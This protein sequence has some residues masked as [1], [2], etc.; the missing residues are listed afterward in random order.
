MKEM[1]PT[2]CM[3]S[4][5]WY[6]ATTLAERAALRAG[7]VSVRSSGSNNEEV[8]QRLKRWK[9]QPPFHHGSYFA[10]RLA[11]DSLT[12]EDLLALLAE[13]VEVIRSYHSAPPAWLIE[14][15]R[16]FENQDTTDEV[17]PLLEKI[18]D[19]HTQ[20]FLNAVKPLLQ[21]GF[22]RLQAGIREIATSSVR[23][24][25]DPQ[26]ILK[27]FAP[28]IFSSIMQDISRTIVLELNVA[29]VQGRLQ[30]E[31]PEERFHY[32]LQQ[33]AQPENLL[34]L[35]E[36]YPVLARL[37]V[38]KIDRWAT[39]E[40]EFLTR[41]CSDWEQ[42]L[43]VFA[44]SEDPGVL[45]EVHEG[46]GDT[47]RGGHSVMTL[48]WSSGF[49]L[50]YKPRPLAVDEHFQE[51]LAW[52]NKEGQQPALRTFKLINKGTYGWCEFVHAGDC[53]SIE[54]VERFYERQGAYLA[55]LYALEATDFHA[56][57][58]IAS[59]EHPMLIDL[60][61][62]FQPHAHETVGAVLSSNERL[63]LKSVLRIGLLP[64][65]IMSN[66]QA[67]GID[68]SG[69]GG[70]AGQ[71]VPIAAQAWDGKGTDQ[72]HVTRKH[73]E[74]ALG[75]HRPR[76][77]GQEVDTLAHCKSIIA[78]FST[79][80]RLLMQ[81]R[82]ELLTTIL[83]RFAHDEIRS[84]HRAS[85]LYM[86]LLG[87]SFHPNVL[88]DALDRD[89]LFDR[90]WIGIEQQP[91]LPRI[92]RAEQADLRRGD[93]P[94]FSTYPDSCDLFTSDGEV[95][96]HCF[97]EASMERARQRIRDLDEQDLEKQV[98]IIQASFT[99]LLLGLDTAPGNMLQLRPSHSSMTYERLIS[100]ARAIGDRLQKRA[101]YQDDTVDWLG[102]M[103]LKEREWY[104]LP[105]DLDLYNGL[106]GIAFFLAY[107]G[108]LTGEE[109]YTA[110]ARQALENVRAQ[111]RRRREQGWL[112]S[113]GIG[114]FDGVG[115]LIYLFSHLGSLWNQPALYR[116]AQEIV[117]LLPDLI[118]KDEFLDLIAGSAG[119][120]LALLSLYAAAPSD[121]VLAAAIRCGDHL[122]D[123]ARPMPRG[124]GWSTKAEKI[125]LTGLA[126]GNAG[127]AL[128]LLRLFGVSG[129]ERFRQAALMAI[130]Y[131]RGLFSAEQQN[132][133]DLRSLFATRAAANS[134]GDHERKYPYMMAW[135]HGAPGIGL[136]RLEALNYCDDAATRG[137]IEAAL[138]T[139]LAQG[140]GRNHCLCHGD[141]GNLE[142]LLI[143]AQRLNNSSYEEQ[144]ER[145]VPM[146]LDSMDSQGWQSGIPLGVETPGLMM[147]LA[148]TGYGLLRLAAL[149]RIPSVLLLEPPISSI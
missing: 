63:R 132:W 99:S 145:L 97:Y 84:L 76:L 86:R 80:Y 126:H 46:A 37:M 105:A 144:I 64:Q 110:L 44:P 87:D 33:L 73:I 23:L 5:A 136:A 129:E 140:F 121:A 21:S 20:D 57:N 72:M 25:F 137:E 138:K 149:E 67:V 50:V 120:I 107:L 85:Q 118:A 14:L 16:A 26:T 127:M 36:E 115:S 52:L 102:V 95:I 109:S 38:E 17:A 27:L 147:G 41:L 81:H 58:L 116:E 77:N 4:A 112:T 13:P 62:L 34:S 24:P 66:E 51:L 111:V 94:L 59:G 108:M 54:E 142:L 143:A 103:A 8:K 135:C 130:E 88:R 122:I 91:N 7:R 101:L 92:I 79:T 30:G 98:W 128:S 42:I 104:L 6:R 49:R 35:L 29:R 148:G 133:P 60:E 93:I 117:E 18:E 43:E 39:C 15:G 10:Q 19:A 106:P 71:I 65:R 90:L 28:R 61:A 89:R 55:L 69:L 22:A 146:L 114:A 31:A 32:F 75:N 113:M 96:P 78:G 48:T 2:L 12:E 9:E 47:H 56:E 100:D 119:C 123:S 3:R 125:P 1:L 134:S 131:E 11:I 141:L 70:Q 74:L 139:T 53:A 83:P 45:T 82:D 40:L 68:V 124:I